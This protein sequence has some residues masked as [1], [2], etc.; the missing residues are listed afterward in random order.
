MGG[1][2]VDFGPQSVGAASFAQIMQG[3]GLLFLRLVVGGLFLSQ[4][5][6]KLVPMWGGS[7]ADTANIF[8]SVGMTPGYPLAVA[9]G[10]VESIGGLLMMGGAYTTWIATLLVTIRVAT[11]WQLHTGAWLT[12]ALLREPAVQLDILLA[13]AVLCLLLAGPGVFSIDARRRRAAEA[14]ALGKARLRAHRT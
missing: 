5:L 2:G 4:G 12:M 7:P 1:V 10:I 9:T 11:A 14:D 3:L 8:Q 6:P 13:G